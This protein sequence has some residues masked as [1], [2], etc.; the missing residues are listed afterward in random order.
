MTAYFKQP[1]SRAGVTQTVAAGAASAAATNAF[2]A[3]TYQVRLVANTACHFQIGDGAQTATTSSP[4]LPA[5]RPEYVTV[6][7]GQHIAAIEAATGGLVTGTA[8]TL[9]VTEMS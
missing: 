1:S 2:G 7:P 8:G 3:Q 4:F 6:T 5:N 9:W